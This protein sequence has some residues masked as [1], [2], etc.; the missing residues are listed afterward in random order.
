VIRDKIKDK[1]HFEK[2]LK[3]RI[4]ELSEFKEILKNVI[5]E[6]G[7]EDEGA[8]NGQA[9]IQQK[10]L[11]IIKILYSLGKGKEEIIP[12]YQELLDISIL[13]EKYR[14]YETLL[15]LLS[16]GVLLDTNKEN[17]ERI[18]KLVKL[19]DPNDFLVDYMLNVIANWGKQT[20]KVLFPQA[21]LGLKEVVDISDSDK[22][23]GSKR[24]KKYITKEWY[25][26]HK[27]NGWYNSH[28]SSFGA[29]SGYWSWESGAIVKILDLDDASLKDVPYYPYDIVHD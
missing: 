17:I 29:Y 14:S 23:E 24:L 9:I 8:N 27:S 10:C 20:E 13:F 1:E 12:Y 6:R 26:G 28:N 16:L 19:N 22:T 7:I 3:S 21:Y 2:Y 18:I 4:A 25:K 15:T 11:S 5:E